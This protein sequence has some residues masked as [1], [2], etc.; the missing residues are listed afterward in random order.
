MTLS[1]KDTEVW[2]WRTRSGGGT[3]LILVGDVNLQHRDNPAD[4]FRHVLPTLRKADV[5]FGQLEGPLSPPSTDPF[6]PDIPH[7]ER[8]SHSDPKMVEGFV[9]AGFAA[10]SCASNVTYP[11][12]AALNSLAT[13][14]K[15]GIKH[16]G[17]GHDRQAARQP[18]ILEKG[19]VRFGFLSYTSVFWPVGHAAGESTPGVATVKVHTAY[20]PDRRALEM[21]GA[22]PIVLTIPDED[23]LRA[24]EDDVRCLHEKTDIVVVS[25]HWGVSGSKEVADYQRTLGRAAIRAGADIV[26]G[27]HPHVLQEIEVY[28]GRP[29]FYSMGNFAFD[30]E[31][32]L[33]RNLEGLLVR[34]V[35]RKKR[36][37]EISFVP[38]Q[39][40]EE[41]LIAILDP[42]EE[43]GQ[44]VVEEVRARS[45]EAGTSL[46]LDGKEVVVDGVG[47]FA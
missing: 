18:A 9:A 15:M 4:A 30:W 3:T 25:C 14:D 34:C 22:P 44:A 17:A 29:I 24:M 1:A 6:F 26:M 36:L 20:Q 45:Q 39:R 13:L 35:V 28:Q 33:S 46:T 27:H 41:N 16:C 11:P 10:M 19:G 23:E 38:V 12:K 5:L 40:D 32:M 21:P 31:K 43:A 47:V 2:S 7:K 8:W 37:A 42:N